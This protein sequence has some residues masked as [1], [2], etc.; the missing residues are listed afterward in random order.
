MVSSS[1]NLKNLEARWDDFQIDDENER[2][3]AFDETVENEVNFDARWCLVG[4]ILYDRS[5]DY[6]SFRNVMASLWRAVKGMFVKELEIN[7]YLFQFFHELDIKRVLEGSPWTFNHT[8][9][10]LERLSLGENPRMVILN[11]LEIW[12]QVYDL[13]PGF[14]SDRILKACGA[15]MGQFV[16][17]CPKNYTGIWREYLRV[18]VKIDIEKPLKRRMKIFTSKTDFFWATFKYERLPTFCFVCGVLGHSE[19][20]CH[21]LF[22]EGD[23]NMSRPY[24][25]FMRAPDRRGQRN[26]G[27]RWLRDNMARPLESAPEVVRTA[28]ENRQGREG[29]AMVPRHSRS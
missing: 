8:L 25:I 13:K 10:I 12:V 28:A 29:V 3:L 23:E 7:K 4:K 16:A 11:K 1:T 2:G 19:S 6:N 22:D 21:K 14:M 27:A 5:T 18:R 17:S 20:F 9:I 24:G 26:I 15:Y